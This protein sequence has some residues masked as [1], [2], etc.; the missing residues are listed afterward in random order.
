MTEAE[1]RTLLSADI[2]G[3]FRAEYERMKPVLA[4]VTE[5]AKAQA[6]AA[7]LF[8]RAYERSARGKKEASKRRLV[9]LLNG[10]TK[11]V[12]YLTDHAHSAGELAHDLSTFFSVTPEHLALVKA[13]SPNSPPAYLRYAARPRHKEKAPP[14]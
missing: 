4:V 2:A 11:A 1:R 14:N 7:S 5:Y 6:K 9:A 3:A 10:Y 8:A 13:H 12:R